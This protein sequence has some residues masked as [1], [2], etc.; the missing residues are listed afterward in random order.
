[1]E[2]D[3]NGAQV[4]SRTARHAYNLV[5]AE[6]LSG[7]LAEGEKIVERELIESF[8]LPRADV[9]QA[10]QQL[11]N[12]GLVSRRPR[13]G[14]RV[15]HSRYRVMIDDIAP[16]GASGD[17]RVR[18]TDRRKAEAPPVV[19]EHLSTQ[20][21]QVGL[22]ERLCEDMRGSMPQPLALGIAFCRLGHLEQ[23][24]STSYSRMHDGFQRVYGCP[25]GSVESVLSAAPCDE[26]TAKELGIPWG[27]T[28]LVR[29]QCLRGSDGTAY[30]YVF[31]YF[32][33]D[34]VAFSDVR[35]VKC[36]VD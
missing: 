6:I 16:I 20:E 2:R 15:A 30:Q 13:Y 12:E 18:V 4:G 34:R 33:A 3:S 1:M 5:R 22:V 32:R 29:E 24:W 8:G 27:A 10:L 35:T 26:Y 7:A 19:Q 36:R 14:T 25:L 23:L 28:V 31:S 9:R 21:P 11:A 17:F